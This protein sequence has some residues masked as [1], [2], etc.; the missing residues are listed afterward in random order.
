MIQDR[1]ANGKLYSCIGKNFA[2]AFAWLET[3][4]PEELVAGRVEIKGDEIFALVQQYTTKE[5]SQ[6]FLETHKNYADIQ[7]V[8]KGNERMGYCYNEGMTVTQP[9]SAEKD[10][11]KYEMKDC[12]HLM[13]PAGNFA[14]FLPEDAH[15]PQLAYD[16]PSEVL[17]IVLKVK[18]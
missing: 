6:G 16:K 1:I 11:E 8:L 12:T 10:V 14:I 5:L 9:Y 18:L 15:A 13:V 17:K 3:V 7:I 4:K 2:E